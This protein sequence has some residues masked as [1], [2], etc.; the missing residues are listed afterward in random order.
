MIS[1]ENARKLKNLGLEWNPKDPHSHYYDEK[2]GEIRYTFYE[3]WCSPFCIKYRQSEKIT[4]LPTLPQLLE[5]VEEMGYLWNLSKYSND[6]CEFVWFNN[7][8]PR[9]HPY[10]NEEACEGVISTIGPEDAVAL[11]LIEILDGK[12]H[13]LEDYKKIFP[14]VLQ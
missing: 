12:R 11:A 5:E 9:N 8:V 1:I 14:G 2:K 7:Q 6:K 13:T 10:Y 4:W 3:D